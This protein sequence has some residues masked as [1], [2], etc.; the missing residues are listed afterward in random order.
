MTSSKELTRWGKHQSDL[1]EEGGFSAV[2]AEEG[3]RGYSSDEGEGRKGKVQSSLLGLIV[4]GNKHL[5]LCLWSPPSTRI[6]R[7]K[8]GRRKK[9]AWGK[10][11][12]FMSVSSQDFSTDSLGYFFLLFFLCYVYIKQFISLSQFKHLSG[13]TKHFRGYI[14][15]WGKEKGSSNQL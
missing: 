10:A 15:L 11:P 6:F 4:K 7:K 9:P 3:C 13:N 5:G 14:G 8:R 1:G 12:C 2:G